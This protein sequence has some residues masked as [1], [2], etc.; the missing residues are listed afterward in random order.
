MMPDPYRATAMSPSDPRNPQ[1]WNRFSYV[2]GDPIN[3]IDPT[4]LDDCPGDDGNFY[5]GETP[6]DEGGYVNYTDQNTYGLYCTDS[7]GSNVSCETD[8]A[9][10]TT[11]GPGQG[12]DTSTTV[13]ASSPPT[14]AL[15][16][17]LGGFGIWGAGGGGVNFTYIPGS[18]TLCVGL[19]GGVGTPGKS[20]NGGYLSTTGAPIY[21]VV[22][23]LSF[24]GA[25]QLTPTNGAPGK[26]ESGKWF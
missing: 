9:V 13:T 19:A 20:A 12:S 8:G 25:Y 7:S 21:N 23:H 11:N 4:G 14:T 18:D 26:L 15:T 22:N 5:S 3:G 1:S 10:S 24:T 6:C 2:L 16:L 17:F